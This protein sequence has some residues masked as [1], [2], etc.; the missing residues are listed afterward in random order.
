M[1][2]FLINAAICSRL[3]S[4]LRC[5]C[6][7]IGWLLP[8]ASG[9]TRLMQLSQMTGRVRSGADN[10]EI[11]NRTTKHNRTPLDLDR[12][13]QS[14]SL[15]PSTPLS[16]ARGETCRGRKKCKERAGNVIAGLLLSEEFPEFTL[17]L[18]GLTLRVPT[19]SINLTLCWNFIMQKI[20]QPQDSA[21]SL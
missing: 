6:A 10:A 19:V 3:F 13:R 8:S 5:Y 2:L 14:C 18:G 12:S 7:S 17:E 16:I 1:T 11:K 9:Q 4:W 15:S 20:L 21:Q